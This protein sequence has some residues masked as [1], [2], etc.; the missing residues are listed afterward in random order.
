MSDLATVLTNLFGRPFRARILL[1]GKESGVVISY[2]APDVM[3]IQGL[4]PG[5]KLAH[6]RVQIYSGTQWQ[7]MDDEQWLHILRLM[8]PRAYLHKVTEGPQSALPDGTYAVTGSCR[9]QA[10]VPSLPD[11][12][13]KWLA[14]RNSVS[15]EVTF[16]FDREA[17]LIEFEQPNLPPFQEERVITRIDHSN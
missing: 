1:D 17:E 6:G 7:T 3:E 12:Y 2:S 16:R 4:D 9:V 10:L 11:D 5:F 8:D 13:L 14:E 15:R